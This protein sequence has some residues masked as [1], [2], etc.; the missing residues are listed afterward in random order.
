METLKPSAPS[1]VDGIKQLDFYRSIPTDLTTRT[2]KGGLITIVTTIFIILLLAKETTDFFNDKQYSTIYVSRLKSDDKITV[3]MNI[4]VHDHMCKRM[5]M[6]FRS[7]KNGFFIGNLDRKNI[8]LL[9]VHGGCNIYGQTWVSKA[10]GF[11][12]ISIDKGPSRNVTMHH[13]IHHLSFG[14][15]HPVDEH[16]GYDYPAAVFNTLDGYHEDIASKGE[17]VEYHLQL[18]QTSV[19]NEGLEYH[20]YQFIHSLNHHPTDD[21]YPGVKMYFD[22][23]PITIFYGQKSYWWIDYA[24]VCISIV[25]GTFTLAAFIHSVIPTSPSFTTTQDKHSLGTNL[26]A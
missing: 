5:R 26:G 14:D 24:G 23:S 20:P 7:R 15:E 2:T 9:N 3:H 4:T 6:W 1:T 21:K 16:W 22:W 18:V 13:T 8:E 25:G 19:E 12:E 11:L 10:P 17:D